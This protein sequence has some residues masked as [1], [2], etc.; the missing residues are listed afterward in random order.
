MHFS[1]FDTCFSNQGVLNFT[2]SKIHALVYMNPFGVFLGGSG[3]LYIRDTL[4]C[5][6]CS[7]RSTCYYVI[8][9]GITRLK[10]SSLHINTF[11]QFKLDLK[12]GHTIKNRNSSTICLLFSRRRR[13]HYPRVENASFSEPECVVVLR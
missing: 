7:F 5:S 10:A 3:R 1:A 13:S 2:I 6:I 12:L 11:N 8:F 4:K 9:H